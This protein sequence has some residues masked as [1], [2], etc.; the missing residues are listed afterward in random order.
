MKIGSGRGGPTDEVASEGGSPGDVELNRSEITRGSE[1]TS[2]VD[3]S[4]IEEY[5][6]D[7][8]L[9]RDD[10]PAPKEPRRGRLFGL[11]SWRLP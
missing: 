8:Q 9:T 5:V 3:S 4:Q 6:R 2:T 7:R 10:R 1:A 11:A